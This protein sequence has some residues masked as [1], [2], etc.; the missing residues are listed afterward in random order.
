M[1]L[2]YPWT[3]AATDLVLMSWGPMNGLNYLDAKSMAASKGTEFII[4]G[5][6]P[7]PLGEEAADTIQSLNRSQNLQPLK[8]SWAGQSL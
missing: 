7:A 6:R 3:G 5:E 2:K 1:Q 8:P 4:G